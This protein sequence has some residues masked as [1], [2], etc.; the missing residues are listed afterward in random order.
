MFLYLH[1]YFFGNGPY[2]SGKLP[3]NRGLDSVMVHS[4][5]CELPESAAEPHLGFPG[6]FLD[7]ARQ[8]LLSFSEFS[9]DPRGEAIG[10]CRFDQRSSSMTVSRFRD[11]AALGGLA[12]GI[13]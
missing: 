11:A 8:A 5:G 2:E 4:L 7:L 12:A 9:T 10:L 1:G 13:L 3:R 6:D